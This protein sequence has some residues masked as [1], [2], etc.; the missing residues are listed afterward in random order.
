MSLAAHGEHL[1]S[2]LSTDEDISSHKFI[3]NHHHEVISFSL[4]SPAINARTLSHHQPTDLKSIWETLTDSPISLISRKN[5]NIDRKDEFWKRVLILEALVGLDLA[6]VI[7]NAVT[8]K[9]STAFNE[10]YRVADVQRIFDW[11]AGASPSSVLNHTITMFKEILREKTI[12]MLCNRQYIPDYEDN[13]SIDL[14]LAHREVVSASHAL[15]T[16]AEALLQR[17]RSIIEL[18]TSTNYDFWHAPLTHD[19]VSQSL[20]ELF[21]LFQEVKVFEKVVT[22][23]LQMVRDESITFSMFGFS[24]NG[25]KDCGTLA[26]EHNEGR[27]CQH[28]NMKGVLPTYLESNTL[29]FDLFVE[30]LPSEFAKHCKFYEWNGNEREEKL[31]NLLLLPHSVV[32]SR[33]AVLTSLKRPFVSRTLQQLAEDIDE[34]FLK[35]IRVVL[36][37]LLDSNNASNALLHSVV[38]M[39]RQVEIDTHSL[40]TILNIDQESIQNIQAV[41]YIDSGTNLKIAIERFC[42]STGIAYLESNEF[43]LPMIKRLLTSGHHAYAHEFIRALAVRDHRVLST[44]EGSVAVAIAQPAKGIGFEDQPG[45]RMTWN[46]SKKCILN[47]KPAIEAYQASVDATHFIT[48]WAIRHK[49]LSDLLNSDLDL[50]VSGFLVYDYIAYEFL[51]EIETIIASLMLLVNED[52]K[53]SRTPSS[54]VDT[55]FAFLLRHFRIDDARKVRCL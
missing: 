40:S 12:P 28:P 41:Q 26:K 38:P 31:A 30:Q 25:G 6:H 3:H 32:H 4:Q 29:L 24:Q 35:A 49:S 2:S 47:V 45:W 53:E 48:L 55:L 44:K 10:R 15:I 27:R 52:L 16:I 39:V 17:K 22:F 20:V 9:D 50:G 14:L 18:T 13:S 51:K 7:F 21:L 54:A 23:A 46:A 43:I 5:V 11:V 36:Y 42:Y 8:R 37:L 34:D 19:L 1:L 33:C